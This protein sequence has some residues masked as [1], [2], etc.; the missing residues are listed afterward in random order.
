MIRPATAADRPVLRALQRYLPEPA[1]E[2][3]EPAAGAGFL[4]STA[5]ERARAREGVDPDVAV[6]YLCWLP[7]ETVYVAEL[8]VAPA[9]RRQGRARR[10]F[11]T[12]LDS[13]ESGTTVRLQVA[14]AAEPAQRL[15]RDLGFEVVDRDVDAYE[16]G[17]GLWMATV[18]R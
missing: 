17:A 8:V 3:L 6:G 9:F 1:P 10:L 4:V 15:Y 18:V 14:A 2:L 12:L 13:L 11:E 7:G 16:S 5:G